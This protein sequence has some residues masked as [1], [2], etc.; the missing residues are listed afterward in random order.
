MNESE[1][2]GFGYWIADEQLKAYRAL[3][4]LQRLQWLDETRRFLVLALTEKA[5]VRQERL[6]NGRTITDDTAG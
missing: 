1:R 5:R 2:G 4:P 6:R 3:T